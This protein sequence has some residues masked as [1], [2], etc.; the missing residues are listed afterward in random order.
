VNPSANV[1]VLH[2]KQGSAVYDYIK[3]AIVEAEVLCGIFLVKLPL[4]V[5]LILTPPKVS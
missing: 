4:T 3:L 5:T 2:A 1:P